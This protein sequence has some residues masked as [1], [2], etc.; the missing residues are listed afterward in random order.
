MTPSKSVET[1]LLASGELYLLADRSALA[2]GLT[3]LHDGRPVPLHATDTLPRVVGNR[4]FYN[5]FS[6]KD[7]GKCLSEARLDGTELPQTSKAMVN[8]LHDWAVENGSTLQVQV[9]EFLDSRLIRIFSEIDVPASQETRIFRALIAS[10][11]CDAELVVTFDP[12]ENGAAKSIVIPFEHR[13]VGGRMPEDYQAVSVHSPFKGC[14]VTVSMQLRFLGYRPDHQ[15][16]FPYIFIANAEVASPEGSQSRVQP[17]QKTLGTAEAGVWY[18]ARVPLFRSAGDPPLVLRQGDENTTLFLPEANAVTLIEDYGHLLMVKADRLQP[19]MLF[20]DGAP[21]EMVQ[22]GTE[23]TAIRL[24]VSCLRGEMIDVSI[25]DLSGSQVFLS[26]PVIARRVLTPHEVM[27]RESRAPFPTDLTMRAN[28][29]YKAL[30][31]HL[32]HPM[33]GLDPASLASAARTLDCTYETVKLKPI[34]FPE[35]ADPLVSVIIPAHNKVE[36]TYYALCALLVAH[37]KASFE[38]IVVDDASTD[39]TAEL[40][41]IVSGIRVIHNAEAQRFIRACNAGVAEALGRYVVLLNN[42]TEATT[43]WLDALIDSFARLDNVGLAGSKLLYPDGRLQDA[44]GIIWNTGNPWNYGNR[45]NPWEPRFCYARQADYLSGAALMTTRKIWNEVGGLSSYLEPMYFEDTDFAFKVREAGYKTWFVPSSVVYHFE[46]L[47]SGTDSSTGFKRFQEV[48]R[49][50]FKRRWARDFVGFGKEGQTPDLE[51]D[52]GIVGRVLFIDY[53]TPREDRDAGS[54][55]ARREIELVQSLGYKVTF[56]P[57]NLAHLG[58]YTDALQ[59]SGVEVITAPFHMS[60]EQFLKQRAAEFDAVYITRYYVAQDAIRHIR[61]HAP[62]ARVILN[63]ADLH[64][65]RE[66]RAAMSTDDP[67]RLAAMRAIREQ[68]LEMMTAA[69]LVLSYNEVE[70]AVIASHTDG[71]ARVM[72]CPW[73]VEIPAAVPPLDARRGM[74]FLGSFNHHPNAEGVTWFCTS[75]L[76]LLEGSGA[77]LTIYGAGMDDAIKALASDS[78]DPVGFVED[79]AEAYGRHRIFVAPLLSGAGIKGKVLSALAHGIPTVLTPVAAE[80]IGLRHGHDCLIAETPEDWARAITRL[81][82]DDALWTQI[83]TAARRYAA[84]RFSFA[85]GRARMKAAFEAV[86]LFGAM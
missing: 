51:K 49:P 16:N 59:N 37:N 38:V 20:I 8:R 75:V 58:S 3:V 46:G 81:M 13:Y 17:R 5:Q 12:G 45:A 26:L 29:R 66:L 60:L 23:E 61:E 6:Y 40:E 56:L 7:P 15:D 31:A 55:A 34:A 25:R 42:D 69:D 83:S 2:S 72:T 35:V 85:E 62:K 4:P 54:Y 86:D 33:P 65:L 19:M 28:H 80:G 50:K 79:I 32:D 73:V 11:R 24:P 64:F 68:E 78:V 41:T 43:G 74:S 84:E 21:V 18:R 71:Q 39:A 1:A 36:V 77:H 44:G 27:A 67:S 53:T 82:E 70:H 48:N 63:N 30:R 22:V 14:D 10:H 76:P 52:R 9:D 57:Q 47:T